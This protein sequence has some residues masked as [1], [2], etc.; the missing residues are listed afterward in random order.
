MPKSYSWTISN[1]DIRLKNI[2]Q[3]I[4]QENM[5]K[6]Y[7]KKKYPEIRDQKN[8]GQVF[9]RPKQKG[10]EGHTSNHLPLMSPSTLLQIK[11]IN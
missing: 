11:K 2:D 1:L 8:I 3:K 9:L 7:A 10:T 4:C 5:P 6:K